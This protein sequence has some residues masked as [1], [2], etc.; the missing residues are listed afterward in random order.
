VPTREEQLS[1]IDTEKVTTEWITQNGIKGRTF[2]DKAT[3]NSIFLPAFGRRE[4]DT[5][6]LNFVGEGGGHWS[7]TLKED[8][9]TSAYDLHIYLDNSPWMDAHHCNFGFQVR[10]VAK[11]TTGIKNVAAD[12]EN[13]AVTGYFNIMGRKLNEEPAK[14]IY[15][16][17][18]NNGTTKKV[19]R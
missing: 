11:N 2:T 5:G 18:Y 13:A 19:M 14:G 15:I 8:D 12:T 9:E 7:S 1:L 3:G 10:C 6:I 4:Y 17:L 16:I